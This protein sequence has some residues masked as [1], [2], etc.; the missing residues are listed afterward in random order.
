MRMLQEMMRWIREARR[1]MARLRIRLATV[2]MA[3]SSLMLGGWNFAHR[4]AP[5]AAAVLDALSAAGRAV[6]LKSE[7]AHV[8]T[9]RRTLPQ[10]F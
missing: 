8:C 6:T 7:S 2:R 5:L 1:K 3:C 9:C 4:A 10:L